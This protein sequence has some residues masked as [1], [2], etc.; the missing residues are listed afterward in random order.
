[1]QADTIELLTEKGKFAPAQAVILAAAIDMGIEKAQ[2]V[3]VPILDARLAAVDA[4]FADVDARL[5]RLE[6]RVESGFASLSARLESSSA[7][8][9]ARLES[10][11]A[12][13]SARLESSSA[14]S[15][16]RI[17]SLEARMDLKM[18]RWAVKMI[19]AMLLGQTALGPIGMQAFSS[20]RQAL[21]TLVR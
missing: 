14:L 19:I 8:L 12:S 2:F 10:S 9:S 7:A 6:V 21:S 16:S 3:T 15:Y 4:R 1:M 20:L 5:T 18:H 11:F 17:D 13:L